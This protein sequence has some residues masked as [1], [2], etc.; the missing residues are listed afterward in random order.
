MQEEIK[1]WTVE[2][3]KGPPK[4]KEQTEGTEEDFEIELNEE[5]ALESSKVLG[6][7]V[8]YSQKSY[9]P[10]ILFSD[11]INAWGIQRLAAVEKLGDYMFSLQVR[12]KKSSTGR[13][14][15]VPQRQCC[16]GGSLQWIVEAIGDSFRSIDLWVRLYNLPTAMMKPSIAQQLGGQLGEVLKFDCRF[17]GYLRIRERYPLGKPLGP[18]L[19][20]KVKGRGQMVIALKYE[21]VPHFC[22]SCGRIGH[23]ATNCEDNSE[24]HGMVYGEELRA[25]PPRRTKEITVITHP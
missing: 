15:M 12:R 23:A 6:I 19:A 16:A 8:F 21:N 20:V 17:P 18:S 25:S 1:D 10:H 2:V 7:A 13:R 9:N 3:Y 11:M 5:E 24:T 4:S 14:P 22:F